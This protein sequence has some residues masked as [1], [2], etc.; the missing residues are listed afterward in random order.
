M[1][2]GESGIAIR[3]MTAA[4]LA[5]AAHV[6]R[7]A[8]GTH[9]G[10]PEPAR[11]REDMRFIETR[12][13]TDPAM[14]FVAERKGRI[15]GSII[16]M[17]WG[18]ELVLGP[19]SV[20]PQYWGQGV[21]RQLVAR[22]L[23]AADVGGAKLTVL[24][25]F[26]Q[27]TVHLRLYESFGFVPMFLTPILAK[28]AAGGGAAAEGR[29]YSALP[30]PERAA[31]LAACGSVAA[32]VREG[33]DLRR[34]IEAVAAQRLGDTVLIERG[35]RIAGFAVCHIGPGSEAGEGVLFVKFAAVRPG[36]AADFERLLDA[37]EAL[38]SARGLRRIALGVNTGRRDAYRRLVSR[39][40][41]A[42]FVGIAMHRPDEIGT[43][44]PDQYVIDDWR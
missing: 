21:A 13:A 41:R 18:S 20:D 28:D 24:F 42:E 11:F 16:G 12:F 10:A 35:G 43:L 36:S 1:R 44:G 3:A 26:P 14:A 27:S 22:F 7:L 39:G 4:D 17:D 31:A 19:L 25:T 5:V 40:F 32:V 34:Q 37:V 9:F 33:L 30:V 23:E 2:S 8:F 29:L 6:W 15:L 38:G